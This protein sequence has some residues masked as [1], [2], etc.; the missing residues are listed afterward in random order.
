MQQPTR[1]ELRQLAGAG[2][3]LASGARADDM[4]YASSSEEHLASS[5]RT[6][7]QTLADSVAI[8]DDAQTVGDSFCVASDSLIALANHKACAT[9]ALRRPTGSVHIRGSFETAGPIRRGG[10]AM[11]NDTASALGT[12]PRA[13]IV[14]RKESST[15]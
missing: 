1:L 7:S 14:A 6:Q 8:T 2:G 12:C 9:L 10:Y 13:L 11:R 3:L 15:D 5:L 4:L